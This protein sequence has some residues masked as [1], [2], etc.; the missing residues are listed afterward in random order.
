MEYI[1]P[2]LPHPTPHNELCTDSGTLQVLLPNLWVS[3]ILCLHLKGPHTYSSFF[4]T[5]ITTKI[6]LCA[7]TSMKSSLITPAGKALSLS[8][9]PLLSTYHMMPLLLP[10]AQPSP[11]YCEVSPLTVRSNMALANHIISCLSKQSWV[12][13]SSPIILKSMLIF[14]TLGVLIWGSQH[15]SPKTN[16]PRFIRGYYHTSLGIRATQ[17]YC[18]Y[19]LDNSLMLSTLTIAILCHKDLLLPPGRVSTPTPS[20]KRC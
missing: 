20:S 4:K 5:C 2:V 1:F 15:L 7:T 13:V 6:Q 19:A 9:A 17:K 16:N 11:S 14:V 3:F 18:K 10:H 8:W 12:Q